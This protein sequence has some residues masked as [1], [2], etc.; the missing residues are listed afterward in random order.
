MAC[1]SKRLDFVQW[2]IAHGA[3]VNLMNPLRRTVATG[4]VPIIMALLDAGAHMQDALAYAINNN[5]QTA[6]FMMIDRGA[7]L[8][9]AA[10]DTKYAWAT[11]YSDERKRR[12]ANARALGAILVALVQVKDTRAILLNGLQ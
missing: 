10:F 11:S 1:V 7:Q 5:Q 4:N 9:F 3:D 6:A 12:R 2:L 8:G